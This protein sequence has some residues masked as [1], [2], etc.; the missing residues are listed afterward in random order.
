MSSKTSLSWITC[1]DCSS[2]GLGYFHDTEQGDRATKLLGY[3]KISFMDSSYY[4]TIFYI[5]SFGNRRLGFPPLTWE[6]K[7]FEHKHYKKLNPRFDG[8]EV[9]NGNP[10][11]ALN[12]FG[13]A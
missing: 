7:E 13:Y 8:Q 11:I 1:H 12:S 10:C 4:F 5:L 6:I 3:I 9:S 2:L